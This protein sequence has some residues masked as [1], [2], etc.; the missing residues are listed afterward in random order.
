MLCSS[1]SGGLTETEEDGE[2]SNTV[3]AVAI[4]ADAVGRFRESEAWCGA[5]AK[6]VFQR[7]YSQ[8]HIPILL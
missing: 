5:P 7:G 3:S 6:A 4:L 8:T 1:N 2:E